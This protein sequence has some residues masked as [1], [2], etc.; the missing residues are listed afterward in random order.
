MPYQK[1]YTHCHLMLLTVVGRP[2]GEGV[3]ADSRT[4]MC[5]NGGRGRGGVKHRSLSTILF[6]SRTDMVQFSYYFCFCHLA[7]VGGGWRETFFFLSLSLCAESEII[8]TTNC[9]E[10]KNPQPTLTKQQPHF[11]NSK[12]CNFY[13][14]W[15]WHKKWVGCT[16]CH[17][18]PSLTWHDVDEEDF[19][20]TPDK[21]HG[22]QQFNL[23]TVVLSVHIFH[24]LTWVIQ[25]HR[26]HMLHRRT[27]FPQA[28]TVWSRTPADT[29]H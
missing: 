20:E 13:A 27:V 15:V 14:Q 9:W 24:C 5:L 6:H 1:R 19:T 11:S 8:K 7:G 16:G 28:I 26:N 12:Q 25:T 23:V 22:F 3:K 10:Y 18:C 4:D 2:Q 21:L 29:V 17:R